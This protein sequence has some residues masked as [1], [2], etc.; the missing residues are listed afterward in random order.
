MPLLLGVKM[1]AL[2]HG[3]FALVDDEDYQWLSK[4]KWRFNMKGYASRS[5]RQAGKLTTLYMHRAILDAPKGLIVDHIDLNGLN[6]QRA[7]LRLASRKENAHNR[8][9]QRNSKTGLKGVSK[10]Q[11][12]VGWT[13]RIRANEK[14]IY[15][16]VFKTSELA[17]AAYDKAAKKLHGNFARTN[18][19]AKGKRFGGRFAI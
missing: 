3:K 9:N 2:T 10:A 17:A 7:N 1:I 4:R 15:L 14:Y 6:N 18:E 5:I 13:A 19:M 8:G 16:G 12:G 11:K